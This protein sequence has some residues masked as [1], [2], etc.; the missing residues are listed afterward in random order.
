M[1]G[2]LATRIKTALKK[3]DLKDASYTVQKHR[4]RQQ[5]LVDARLKMGNKLMTG[6]YK[7]STK[8]A[9]RVLK[10]ENGNI[11]TEPDQVKQHIH[12]TIA[13][14]LKPAAGSSAPQQ[15]PRQY[16]WELPG[17]IDK[18]TLETDALAG[19]CYQGL[20][21]MIMDKAEYHRCLTSLKSGKLPGPDDI[22]NEIIKAAPPLLQD[23]LHML[24]MLM[25]GTS[26]TPH[27]WKESYT[28]LLFKNKGTILELD[29]FRRIGLENTLYKFWTKVVQ[30]M[31]LN[32]AEK[33]HILSIE[34]GGFRPHRSTIHQLEL[35]TMLLEDARFQQQDLF[36]V[37][38]DL[39]EAFDTIDH[40]FMY[41]IMRDLGYPRDAI[42]VV[43]GMY[44]N[45]FTELVTPYGNTPPI[46]VQRGTLQG[47]S[48]SPF[49][50]ILYLEPLLR[51][52]SI[53]G[54]GYHPGVF[55]KQNCVTTISNGTYADDISLYTGGH[56]DAVTQCDKVGQYADVGEL[57]IS[58]PKC[59]AT[60]AL[61]KR[62][63]DKPFDKATVARLTRNIRMQGKPI[64]SHDPKAPY[65]MLGVWFTMDLNWNHQYQETRKSLKDMATCLSTRWWSSQSQKL[66][67]LETCLKAKAQYAFPLMCYSDSQIEGLDRI[68][69]TVVRA[70]YRLPPGT[71]TAMLR[72]TLVKGGLGNTSLKAAYTT[73]AVKNLTEAL[74]DQ[75]KR[76]MLTWAMIKMQSKAYNHPSAQ[77]GAD[78]VPTYSLRLRQAIQGAQAG[79]YM[80]NDG[81]ET[82]PLPHTLV[83]QTI[84]G[85]YQEWDRDATLEQI[86]KPLKRLQEIGIHTLGQLL[87]HK[88]TRVLSP[89]DLARHLGRTRTLESKHKTALQNITL[90]LCSHGSHDTD[91]KTQQ[92]RPQPSSPN[93]A[94]TRDIHPN[95]LQWVRRMVQAERQHHPLPPTVLELLN[96]PPAAQDHPP[97]HMH[98]GGKRPRRLQYDP[99][100]RQGD[101]EDN[102]QTGVGPTADECPCSQGTE[103]SASE[104]ECFQM[105]TP[106]DPATDKWQLTRWS[107][108]QKMLQA[109]LPAVTVYNELCAFKDAVQDVPGQSRTRSLHKKGKHKRRELIKAQL[110]WEVH[111]K[112]TILEGWEKDLAIAQLKY[113]PAAV[114]LATQDDLE[115]SPLI[116]EHCH[117]EH[118]GDPIA[119]CSTCWRGFHQHMCPD[120]AQQGEEGIVPAAALIE[121]QC[122]ECRY[123]HTAAPARKRE[124][125]LRAVQH[126]YVEWQPKWEDEAT[127]RG[128]GYGGLVDTTKA[129]MDRPDPPPPRPPRDHQLPNRDRQGNRGPWLHTTVGEDIRKKCQFI[130]EATDPHTD[131]IGT[132]QY[133]LQQRMVLRRHT[134]PGGEKKDYEIEMVTVLDPAGRTVGMLTPERAAILHHNYTQVMRDR[135]DVTEQL[136]PKGFAEELAGLLRRYREGMPVPG[137]KRKVKLT[138]HWAT[139]GGVYRKLQ[140]QL[141]Q[142]AKER[143]ASPLNYNPDM[144]RYWSCYPRDQL[145]GA[146][147]DA[148]SCKWTG[149][150]VANPEYE[151]KE[152]YKAVSWAVHSGRETNEPTLT[153]FVLPAW[154]EGSNTAYMKWVRKT[155]DSCK[156]L[157]TIPRTSFTFVPPQA[158]T[159][160]MDADDAGHPHWDIN[161]LLV[162]NE[163]GFQASLPTDEA[164]HGLTQALIDAVNDHARPSI[165]LTWSRLVYQCT[166]D[167]NNEASHEEELDAILFRPPDKIRQAPSDTFTPQ[168]LLQTKDELLAHLAQAVQWCSQPLKYDWTQ[169]VYTDGSSKRVPRNSPGTGLGSGLYVPATNVREEQHIGIEA[170]GTMKQHNTP[171]RAEL[172]GILAALQLGHTRIMTDSANSIHA[173]KAALHSP[174][175]IR[176]HRHKTLLEDIKSAIVSLTETVELIKV[177][178]HA[179]IPGNEYADDIAGAVATTGEA[180]M[181][182][183]GAD[184][185]PRPGKA[186]PYQEVWVDDDRSPTG[187][188][189]EW[190][191]VENLEEGV[192]SR[193]QKRDHLRLGQAKTDTLYYRAMQAALPD[194]SETHAAKWQTLSG[195]TEAMKCTRA[196]YL[197]GQLL[198]GKNMQRYKLRKSALCLCCRKHEDSGH[199]AVA[200]CPAI[201]PMVQERHNA[202][203]RIITKAIAHGDMGADSIAYND[204]GNATK[205]QKSGAA[206]LHRTAA[207][208][209]RDLL[210]QEVFAACGSRPDIILYRRRT[211]SKNTEGQWERAPAE[212]TLIEVKYTRDTDPK[213]TFRDPYSQHSSLY[214]EIEARHPSAKVMRRAIVLGVAGTIFTDSTI[215]PMESIGVRGQHLQST[216]AKL[217]RH[218]IQSLHETWKRRQQMIREKLPQVPADEAALQGRRD[219]GG[220]GAGWGG[221][222]RDVGGGARAMDRAGEG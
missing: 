94:I 119:R 169:L 48:L 147:H 206:H 217:Q 113:E 17:A 46:R 106:A 16:P 81:Q 132:G 24:M 65:K 117:K 120:S 90:F 30:G 155:P 91:Q 154:T 1:G 195:V 129:Q 50:F 214:K 194:I 92:S 149:Y 124:T 164:V 60:A 69:D 182:L 127:V 18:F 61:Y 156:L 55:K 190:E 209:P 212:I 72:E 107:R 171:Y 167:G 143:F 2:R 27:K 115:A 146:L 197:T 95:R 5:K 163:A 188:R 168:L 177:K 85:N 218:A 174:T 56:S 93:P 103:E 79:I 202:A 222:E 141:P 38:V 131:I 144:R 198:T 161:I 98:C 3:L 134:L 23:C 41:K 37:Q 126:W 181:D 160:G 137:T 165:P 54:R 11:I 49:L 52:L 216:L 57:T 4:E 34:Q 135:P 199:H 173:I 83:A 152:M 162:G 29:Y 185:N 15:A 47:D 150:S 108:A 32:Y 220:G 100:F 63:P 10:D 191:Q 35:H 68:M 205:W 20:H 40:E 99:E 221:D 204:G 193:V 189:Q 112:P 175:K 58:Q 180:D 88:G 213:R 21:H 75:G 80:W 178:G 97:V 31:L 114:R 22:P 43:R 59:L 28:I 70:A 87:N 183:S 145:F 200:W 19:A 110:Q 6:Q 123:H 71:P 203:V 8:H 42:Q 64:T 196:K 111:W 66:R 170:A 82:C 36:L 176:F 51:W 102:Q 186:W 151:A 104:D 201:L 128:L 122:K 219:A 25:W 14:K 7:Q 179:G 118:E 9:L 62:Q 45:A 77:K 140:A 76:G 109:K 211:L 187:R 159:M 184:S 67:V 158:A 133:E 12:E 53:G 39:K 13:E 44:E 130:I 96:Q 215:W 157:A 142:L 105:L 101:Y 172:I 138:N 73:T 136:E 208:I 74:N 121:G 116:C 148:Y 33:Y 207:D 153:V 26:C 166:R 210:P 84:L 78:W 192:A 86:K 125:Y 89:A 139:P